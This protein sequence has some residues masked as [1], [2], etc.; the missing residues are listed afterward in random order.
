MGRCQVGFMGEGGGGPSCQLG[1]KRRKDGY[2]W[3]GLG[4]GCPWC[5]PWCN[6]RESS[7]PVR[8]CG[9]AGSCFGI[10]LPPCTGSRCIGAF[11]TY[12]SNCRSFSIPIPRLRGRSVAERYNKEPHAALQQ[13][14]QQRAPALQQRAPV[15]HGRGAHSTHEHT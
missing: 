11:I 12:T 15:R 10:G 6:G 9:C 13:E 14:P 4:H 7:R 1:P 2:R 5:C 3:L 8:R